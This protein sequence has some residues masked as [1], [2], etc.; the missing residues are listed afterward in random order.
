MALPYFFYAING[1]II[2]MSAFFLIF[3]AFIAY[4][5]S[6]VFKDRYGNVNTM[7]VGVIAFCSSF[8]IVYFGRNF[9]YT[10][11]TNLRIP[12]VILYIL[13]GLAILFLLYLFR[14][15]IKFCMILMLIGAGLILMGALTDWFYNA[16]FV[17]V[18]GIVILIFGFW[19]CLKKK[20]KLGNSDSNYIDSNSK[21]VNSKKNRVKLLIK[22]SK[23]FKRK[24]KK[25]KGSKGEKNPKFYGGW[26]H[27]IHYLSKRGYGH[28]EA[29]IAGY[30]L[31]SKGE[32]VSIFNRYGLVK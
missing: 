11:L 25:R 28:N 23:R 24:A 10:L 1:E 4:I 22:E 3:L 12:S 14:K 29:S 15:K 9:M 13:S 5:L 30:F 17:I 20:K 16:W 32:F 6:K 19:L 26:A 21:P 2:A 7:T 31:V 27:F 8:L 18:F